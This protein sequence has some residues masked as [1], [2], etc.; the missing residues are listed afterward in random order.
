VDFFLEEFLIV[1]SI[2]CFLDVF[3]TF[4]TGE[5]DSETGNLNPKPFFPRWILGL[6]LQLLV[7]PAME[8]V[9]S[10]V[11]YIWRENMVKLG[12]IRVIRWSVA[13]VFPVVY[14][15]FLFFIDYVWMPLVHYEN[16]FLGVAT[17]LI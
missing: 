4:F 14:Y 1:V 15:S 12:P 17:N 9:S 13:V 7:N 10:W 8:A 5:L 16:T 6:V 3:I 11:S 2:V